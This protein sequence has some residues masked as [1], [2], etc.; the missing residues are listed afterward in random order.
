MQAPARPL[1]PP[2][3]P[4]AE[5]LRALGIA[6]CG[7]FVDGDATAGTETELH[8]AVR[9]APGDVDLPRAVAESATVHDLRRRVDRGDASPRILSDIERFLEQND[10]EVW[11]HSWVVVRLSK[12]HPQT[13]A[14]FEA[15][16]RRD[17][18]DAASP[19][20]TD[21]ERFR[22]TRGGEPCARVPVSYVLRLAL[23]DAAARWD[24][25]SRRSLA[26]K[27]A[28]HFLNDNSSPE[29]HSFHVVGLEPGVGGRDVADE[30]AL[31]YLVSQLLAAWANEVWDARADGQEVLTYF[32]S[33]TPERQRALNRAVPD[34]FYRELFMSPCLSGWRHGEDKHRY[35]HLCHEVMSRSHLNA[36]PRLR[37]AGLLGRNLVVLPDT[38]TTALQNN[39]THISL[40]SRRMTRAVASGEASEADEKVVTDLAIKISECF[41]PLFVGLYAADPMRL[42][43]ADFHPERLLGYLVHE[44]SGSDLRRVWWRWRHKAGLGRLGRS[45]TPFGPPVWDAAWAKALRL[46]GDC[47]VDY[48]LLDY[49]TALPST[50]RTG[51]FDGTVGN[52]Q[53]LKRELA[54][55]GV[56]DDR[57]SFYA[58]IKNREQG[59]IGFSGVE[60]R[61]WSAFPSFADDA[62]PAVDLQWLVTAYAYELVRTGRVTH[63]DIPD[64]PASESERR[65]LLFSAAIGLRTFTI[66]RESKNRWLL[67]LL[68]RTAGVRRSKRYRDAWKVELDA[69]RHALLRAIREDA[70]GV[71]EAVRGDEALRE[72]HARIGSAR[73]ASERLAS[74]VCQRLGASS[75]LAADASRFN[76]AAER[77]ARLDA[78]QRHIDEAFDAL[79]RRRQRHPD[80]V[81]ATSWAATRRR[82][83][84][85]LV[86]GR[87]RGEDLALALRV[88]LDLEAATARRADHSSPAMEATA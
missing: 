34:A 43:F 50:E 16:L 59:R 27:L 24:D 20:R 3:P 51:A 2:A 81:D 79:E 46:P 65:L 31:R 42:E 73:A 39:G 53:R 49:L 54:E 87:P 70:P 83:Q 15:D 7:P 52:Q 48:R 14:R 66:R 44:L 62:G 47:V 88:L 77:H 36:L 12:L 29:T 1:S 11:D 55:M 56:F 69:F 26:E 19:L 45:W 75:P 21:A 85:T 25:A 84:R 72:T 38:S 80:V 57:M 37:D 67:G 28:G 17:A 18:L 30:M 74:D 86:R 6:D 71:V 35:M 32:A 5:A 13:L 58:P 64:D 10:D 41:L 68:Q 61:T 8:A 33:H 63:A 82:L 23:L 78:R 76:A 40:G 22:T 9:G 60:W 4:L